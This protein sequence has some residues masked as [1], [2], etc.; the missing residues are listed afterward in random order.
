MSAGKPTDPINLPKT[1]TERRA[2]AIKELPRVG[3]GKTKGQ[4]IGAPKGMNR[5]G[6]LNEMMDNYLSQMR[7]GAEGRKWYEEAGEEILN[8]AGGT[9]RSF[10]PN[11]AAETRAR[12]FA[13]GLGITSPEMKV[14]PNLGHAI[15]AHNQMMMGDPVY[16][17]KY[18]NK[19]RTDIEG[20]YSGETGS[21]G[22]KRDPFV[23][24]L[25]RGGGFDPDPASAKRAVHDI[26]DA[27][28]HGYG[29]EFSAGLSEAQHRFLDQVDDIMIAEANR[30]GI[31]GFSSWTTGRAQAAV[32]IAQK[33][34]SEGT[35]VGEA[36]RH[37]G[38]F[39]EK[40]MAQL[41]YESMSG[42]T[43]GNLP[44]LRSAKPQIQQDYHDKVNELLL[45]SEGRDKLAMGYGLLT[46]QSVHGPGY[47]KGIIS[48]GTS[49]RVLASRTPGNMG[50]IDPSS[51][52]LIEA[53]EG[54]R[55]LLLGQ[56]AIA[57]NLPGNPGEALKNANAWVIDYGRPIN[58]DELVQLMDKMQKKYGPE[59][60]DDF[61]PVPSAKGV[62]LLF[63]GDK[64]MRGYEGARGSAKAAQ[65]TSKMVKKLG[66]ELKPGKE[67]PVTFHKN[68]VGGQ[69]ALLE[70][71]YAENAWTKLGHQQF[72]H[73]YVPL[74]DDPNNTRFKEKFNEMAPD[75][76]AGLR[77]IDE[78]M[79]KKEGWTLG[80]NL[81]DVREAI[82]RNGV[83][84][85]NHLIKNGV[86][87]PTVIGL[88][89]I[90][91]TQKERE[92]AGLVSPLKDQGS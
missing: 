57:F 33:A 18:P 68:I 82:A 10:Y 38:D 24:Q 42:G 5:P 21:L 8:V 13:S 60:Y 92:D 36:A 12:K 30:R 50:L 9:P 53:T 90:G 16:A 4:Y 2:E 22:M 72:G 84:G 28:A 37:Y 27:R 39:L 44:Q 46:G 51:Q 3:G 67:L 87:P 79:K 52:R 70:Y 15:R 89:G 77:R 11:P 56:D 74:F 78:S 29:T 71:G 73:G 19:M 32:W 83:D 25:A 40:Y 65:G 86:V 58:E 49:A 69:G 35:P 76:A 85:L 6:L 55:G 91:L 31:G 88:I 26:W 54:T 45:D 1:I 59:V 48:P 81:Q 20:V 14:D 61:A 41:S 62:R 17:G 47:Y 63:V 64:G 80:K 43:T 7:G 75:I 66:Q 23:Q 34:Q